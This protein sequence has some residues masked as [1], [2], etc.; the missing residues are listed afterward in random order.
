MQTTH[1]VQNA[2]PRNTSGLIGI[3]LAV[4]MVCFV[5]MLGVF[6]VTFLLKIAPVL[7]FFIA[8]GGGVWY[9]T[10]KADQYK[11]RA[12]TTVAGGLLLMVLGIIF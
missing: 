2:Q 9:F 12:M 3:F 7:G 10:A 5:L 4:V 1:N 11:L 6:L 8:I